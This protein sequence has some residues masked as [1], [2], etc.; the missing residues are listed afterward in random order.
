MKSR[1]S[2]RYP[3][4]WQFGNSF[5]AHG[6]GRQ[7]VS[8]FGGTKSSWNQQI[9]W[10]SNLIVDSKFLIQWPTFKLSGID[11]IVRRKPRL[12]AFI[13]WSFGWVRS[14]LVQWWVCDEYFSTYTCIMCMR[15]MDQDGSLKTSLGSLGS[16][17]SVY[18]DG[19]SGREISNEGWNIK[20]QSAKWW[21][22]DESNGHCQ[23]RVLMYKCS[24]IFMAL[25]SPSPTYILYERSKYI[26]GAHLRR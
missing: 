9:F 18:L 24:F 20:N 12:Q 26:S 6:V 14:K 8:C 21:E 7:C 5:L 1:T 17:G 13:S 10:G 22:E 2:Y 23:L 3:P 25:A 19:L 4:H 15:D 16:L 11:Y